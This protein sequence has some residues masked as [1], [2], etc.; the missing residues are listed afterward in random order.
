VISNSQQNFS[1]VQRAAASP[2]GFAA[3]I[4]THLQQKT[5]HREIAERLLVQHSNSPCVQRVDAL[6]ARMRVLSP[7]DETTLIREDLL[8]CAN[9]VLLARESIG[10]L[11]L[12]PD[13]QASVL[14]QTK[15]YINQL[16]TQQKTDTSTR[17]GFDQLINKINSFVGSLITGKSQ[18]QILKNIEDETERD[19]RFGGFIASQGL[20]DSILDSLTDPSNLEITF[21]QFNIFC[22]KRR[23]ASQTPTPAQLKAAMEAELA[24]LLQEDEEK[25]K[26][27]SVKKGGRESTS[28]TSP[29]L[30]SAMRGGTVSNSPSLSL[31]PAMRGNV[32]TNLLLNK[33]F[34]SRPSLDNFSP[35]PSP[36]LPTPK[37][38]LQ[39][40]PHFDS[41][42]GVRRVPVREN[43]RSDSRQGYEELLNKVL[44]NPTLPVFVNNHVARWNRS[45]TLDEVRA[46]QDLSSKGGLRYAE[47]K[48]PQIVEQILH[49]DAT[50]IDSLLQ[51][52]LFRKH[53][54]R[55]VSDRYYLLKVKLELPG[56]SVPQEWTIAI[57]ALSE[58]Q[59]LVHFYCHDIKELK[60][61]NSNA[62]ESLISILFP[63][64]EG[65]DLRSNSVAAAQASGGA[66][67]TRHQPSDIVTAVP[68][69]NGP[70]LLK[71]LR[72]H[73]LTGPSILWIAPIL[74]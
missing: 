42:P 6:N 32:E 41:R 46:F 17:V 29:S 52:E 36:T 64:I 63:A 16:L 39:F 58:R 18:G 9:Y 28:S 37:R 12:N 14:E 49:H 74:G 23:Q 57:T 73:P 38:G 2:D 44:N 30:G 45:Q 61:N 33:S 13:F 68:Q 26:K 69:E 24:D 47:M 19:Y 3:E 1:S 72:Q 20:A 53:Y 10:C 34:G 65:I 11:P 66:H 25:A 59:E 54:T 4:A 60:P 48:D 27:K 55:C 50:S 5:Q 67:S 70:P 56:K 22:K 51:S 71:V 15:T 8:A 21:S 31:S 62:K 40:D 7:S 35:S 43:R